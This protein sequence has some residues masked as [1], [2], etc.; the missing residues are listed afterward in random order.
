M[1]DKKI[2]QLTA[3]VSLSNTDVFPVV[4][5]SQTKKAT[6]ADIKSYLPTASNTQTGLLSN[7]DWSTFNNKQS[8]LTL[9]NLTESTSSVLTITGA[10]GAIIGSGVTLQVKQASG[11]Q[12]GYLSSTDWTTFNTKQN[13]LTL[14]TTG[15]GAATLVGSTLNIP[16]GITAALTSLNGQSGAS[17]TFATATT[18]TDFTIASVSNVHTFAI[19]SASASN[20]GLLTS[21][22]W[23]TFN[24]K[25]PALTK[26]NLTETTSSVL[27][28]TGGTGAVIGSGLTIAVTR[29]TALADGYL[30][31]TD[32][33]TFAAKQDAITLTTT[34]TS[35]AATLVGSTLN[36]PQY[37]GGGGGGTITSVTGTSPI[38]SSGGTT[39]D[40]SIA[41]AKAD[42][43]TKGAATFRSGDFDDDGNG[44]ISIDYTNGVASSS[45]NKGFLTSTDWTNFNTAYT[46]RITSLTTTG[47]SG[48][49]TLS[50]NT[51]NIPQYQGALTLTTTGTSGAATLSSNTLNIPQYS[52]GG[53]DEYVNASIPSIPSFGSA[54]TAESI[55]GTFFDLGANTGI[56][57]G[58]AYFIP[59]WVYKSMT[60]TGVK[61]LQATQGV[62]TSTNF[63]GVGLYTLSSGT[64]TRVAIST[65][66]GNIWKATANTMSS[67]AFSSTYSASAGLYF[68]AILYC[69][70]AQT[71]QPTLATNQAISTWN[72]FTSDFTNSAKLCSY[73]G[74]QTT[75]GT[76]FALSS[77]TNVTN[78]YY[79]ALY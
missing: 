76:S 25:E 29:A 22:D 5:G 50:S 57:N 78:P 4:Q 13:S 34:G 79:V 72:G 41:N 55:L 40:I 16:T 9:G 49:A 62:Y 53:G 75:L 52:G 63:N 45:S 33:S 15:T 18:G 42:T 17:Q 61:W 67:K 39:P 2:S 1:A 58:R 31:S 8:A 6:I 26:G 59:V 14:T 37:S 27:T 47:T 21:T 68:V 64:L 65:D 12:S 56:V 35:G 44:L 28:I 51:L 73:I 71:T 66:D 60:I 19:P 69:Q 46:N 74:S 3:V 7:T 10:T 23:S 43:S 30:K 36:I 38:A 11:S 48:A 20:R 32:F 70:S 54:V 77:A 24:S